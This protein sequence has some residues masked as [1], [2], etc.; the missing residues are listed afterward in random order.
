MVQQ[1]ETHA[2]QEKYNG[3]DTEGMDMSPPIPP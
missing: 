3:S 2:S 1:S